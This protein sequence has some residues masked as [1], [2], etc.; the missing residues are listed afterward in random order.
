MNNVISVDSYCPTANV[1]ISHE[2][3]AL[4]DVNHDGIVNEADS[5]LL[6]KY[7]MGS[8]DLNITYADGSN[9]YSY[10]TNPMACDT[11]QDDIVDVSDV[12]LLNKFINGAISTL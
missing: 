5:T 6:L 12:V 8:E 10:I 4:G 2:I 1:A 7:A 9:H 11:T 3:Y